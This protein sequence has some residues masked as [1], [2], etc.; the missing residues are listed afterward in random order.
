MSGPTFFMIDT[1]TLALTPNAIVLSLGVCAYDFEHGIGSSIELFP[2]LD[3][4]FAAGRAFD[5]GTLMWWFQ[6]SAQA[7]ES[8]YRP[9]RLTLKKTADQLS[10]WFDNLFRFQCGGREDAYFLAH[11][12]DFDLPIL[13]T[14]L[15]QHMQM[16]WEGKPGYKKK[17]CFR[18][19]YNMYGKDMEWPSEITAHS[20]LADAKAQAHAHLSLLRKRPDLLE[21]L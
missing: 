3:E 11:G 13:S 10:D 15:S 6:Q 1:E 14:L 7:R 8:Q 4:Q 19:L 9:H 20:A 18:T 5:G 2:S 21:N 12:V 17:L 16:P